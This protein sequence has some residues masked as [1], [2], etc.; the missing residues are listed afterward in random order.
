MCSIEFS[1]AL[2]VCASTFQ[3]R[4]CDAD[5]RKNNDDRRKNN[6]DSIIINNNSNNND[7]DDDDDAYDVNFKRAPSSPLLKDL[8]HP[9][10]PNPLQR[11]HCVHE[12][13]SS[14]LSHRAASPPASTCVS[15]SLY[16]RVPSSSFPSS[17]VPVSLH[18]SP[19]LYTRT[20]SSAASSSSSPP[21]S[22]QPLHAYRRSVTS[23]PSSHTCTHSHVN[24]YTPTYPIPMRRR[25]QDEAVIHAAI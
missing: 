15:P 13:K 20:S 23:M 2:C 17:S 3:E 8:S 7:D 16:A 18:P 25:D 12:R 21:A 6:D 24:T 14:S 19:S 1:I 22:L 5:R 4:D 11:L 10:P 9:L